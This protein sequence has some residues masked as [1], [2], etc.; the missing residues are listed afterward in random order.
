MAPASHRA[1]VALPCAAVLGLGLAAAATGGDQTA[2]QVSVVAPAAGATVSG[3]TTLEASASDNVGVT[4]VTWLVDGTRVAS[5]TA[6]PWQASWDSTG[7][8]D[9]PH[10]I[11]ARAFDAAGN[12]GVSPRVS[13]SVQNGAPAPGPCS[14][15]APPA[16]YRHVVWIVME[17]KVYSQVIGASAAPYINSLASAC[18]LATNFSAES[19][20]SLPN[21][22]AMTSGSTQGISDDGPPS[23]HPLSVPSIFSQLG[24]GWRA[25]EESMP[26]SCDLTDA[27][28]YSVHHNPAVYY[29]DVSGQCAAQDVPLGSTPNISAR[30]TFVTPNTC[31]DMHD[32]SV[33][34]GDSWLSSFLPKILGTSAYA[35]GRTA[36]FLT[37]DEG[38]KRL[39]NHVATIVIAPS[40]VPGTQSGTSFSHYS[41]LR[42]TEELLGITSYL[43][44][45]AGATSMRSA[46][47]L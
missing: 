16:G 35:S 39:G 37:W 34:S 18:G 31:D 40:V 3:T 43:G 45:A 19:H 24:S 11:V 22:I 1:L 47:H 5:V 41:M 8:A 46:F 21:Y 17:N 42:T 15:A 4:R 30:F 28:P 26:S 25:L 6:P 27:P 29:T 12:V 44:S 10:R 7:V 38:S 14:G 9:G 23:K 20:P 32:C 2:P 33:A 13:F 36:V